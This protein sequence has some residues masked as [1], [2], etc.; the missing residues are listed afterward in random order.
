MS[1][2]GV[3]K[4]ILVQQV[5]CQN[6]MY[7]GL[8][9]AIY[10]QYPQ[11]KE[12]YTKSFETN[13]SK[14]LFGSFR[15]I[16]I[17]E[18]L[19]VANLYTQFDFANPNIP[20][21]MGKVYTDRYL[22]VEAIKSLAV[23]NPDSIIY[24]PYNIGCGLGGEKW[25]DI[26]EKIDEI[27]LDNIQILY[28]M[29][30]NSESTD[31]AKRLA[32]DNFFDKILRDLNDNSYQYFKTSLKNYNYLIARDPNSNVEYIVYNDYI[33]FT[34]NLTYNDIEILFEYSFSERI[35]N[36]IKESCSSIINY[37]SI[38]LTMIEE[39]SEF[40]KEHE[41]EELKTALLGG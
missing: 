20:E 38:I 14:R 32:I 8:A 28:T 15:L 18:N 22:L 6:Q 40:L 12:D 2:F 16:D 11:V 1:L 34:L 10:E 41:K 31:L 39:I 19:K 36:R 5:N 13:T 26:I 37:K 17:D 29:S 30:Q 3:T 24:V 23:Q 7:A 33:R 25:E 35:N 4:G 21:T 9:K 27:G